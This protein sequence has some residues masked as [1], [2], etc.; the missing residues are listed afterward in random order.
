VKSGFLLH[1]CPL[2]SK[3]SVRA[4]PLIF[5]LDAGEQLH[6]EDLGAELVAKKRSTVARIAIEVVERSAPWP[7]SVP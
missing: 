5:G 1:D 6:D 2:D 7:N 4:D 3:I